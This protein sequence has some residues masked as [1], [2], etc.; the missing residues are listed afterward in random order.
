MGHNA[1]LRLSETPV[2]LIKPFS[3][4]SSPLCSRAFH[5]WRSAVQ[6]NHRDHGWDAV[7]AFLLLIWWLGGQLHPQGNFF[8]Q[9]CLA[10]KDA[11]LPTS[12]STK[13][14]SNC[15]SLWFFD[16]QNCSR[17]AWSYGIFLWIKWGGNQRRVVEAGGSCYAK[18]WLV[19]HLPYKEELGHWDLLHCPCDCSGKGCSI[20]ELPLNSILITRFLFWAGRTLN[21]ISRSPIFSFFLNS[22]IILFYYFLMI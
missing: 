20:H 9:N 10:V 1:R 16:C 15:V 18:N 19:E 22:K 4:P 8:I 7:G 12:R 6:N 13:K 3:S 17:M 14:A 11:L 5:T 2:H 21:T